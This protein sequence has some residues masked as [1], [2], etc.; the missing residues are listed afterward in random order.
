MFLRNSTILFGAALLLASHASAND[1]YFGGKGQTPIPQRN[2][3]IRLVEEVLTIQPA[4]AEH[5]WITWK[6]TATFTFENTLSKAQ[7]A[8]MGFPDHRCPEL[9]AE[10]PP[11]TGS[12]LL[13]LVVTAGGSTIPV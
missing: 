5:S 11:K 13:N 8:A 3:T 7:V 12:R 4:V 6:I 9:K 10:N 2:D 1:G